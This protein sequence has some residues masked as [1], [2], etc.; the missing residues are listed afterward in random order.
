MRRLAFALFAPL[1]CAL[2]LVLPWRTRAWFAALLATFSRPARLAEGRVVRLQLAFW[3]QAILGTVFYVGIP[4]SRVLLALRSRD[5]LGPGREAPT[6]WQPR[7][8]AE[9]FARRTEDPF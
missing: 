9:E 3:N 5:P 1:C 8:S 7:E 6:Y 2:A 4:L